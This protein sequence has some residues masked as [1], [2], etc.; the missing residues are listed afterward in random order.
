MEQIKAE[1]A[2]DKADIQ[3]RYNTLKAKNDED[4]ETATQYKITCERAMALKEHQS[5]F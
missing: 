5:A 2:S 3:Q 1:A 4:E